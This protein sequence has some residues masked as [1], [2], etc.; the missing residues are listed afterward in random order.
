M[1]SS[2]T[3]N[4]KIEPALTVR[5]LAMLLNVDEK[6]IYR[7]AQRGEVPGFKVSGT[8]RF[9]RSAIN[10]WISEKTVQPSVKSKRNLNR[11]E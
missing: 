3:I 11:N 9:Q 4:L 7:L 5:D 6:T 10:A 2:E 1:L 8:W